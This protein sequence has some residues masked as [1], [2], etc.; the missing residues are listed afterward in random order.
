MG[1]VIN[2]AFAT[3]VFILLISPAQATKPEIEIPPAKVETAS[4]D[5]KPI[6]PILKYPSQVEPLVHG[7]LTSEIEGIVTRIEKPLGHEVKAQQAVFYI[8]NSQVGLQFKEYA[9]R[10]P[11]RGQVSDLQVTLGQYVKPGEV[12]GTVT[13]PTQMKLTVEIPA[14]DLKRVHSG[15]KAT[16]LFERQV[17]RAELVGLSPFVNPRT[18][19]A[20]AELKILDTNFRL[21]PGAVG[22]LQLFLDERPLILVPGNAIIA[23]GKRQVVRT[24]VEDKIKFAD[25]EVGAWID[26]QR[27]ILNGLKP[28]DEIVTR[29]MD[30]LKEGDKIERIP[31]PAK[32]QTL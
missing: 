7:R 25:V 24:V 15:L 28:G 2:S 16:F 14:E 19:T 31:S 1:S 6:Q 21:P 29:T 30:F 18:G 8:K 9:V 26:N 23:F 11:V 4:V 13:D 12:L 10:S 22:Q 5:L 20:R 3:A 32:A 17:L 27:A